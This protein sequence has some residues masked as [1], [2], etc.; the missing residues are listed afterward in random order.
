MPYGY[1]LI[2]HNKREV[3]KGSDLLKLDL[4]IADAASK[5]KASLTTSNGHEYT[6]FVEEDSKEKLQQ[7]NEY[8]SEIQLGEILDDFLGEIER[9][10]YQGDGRAK[11][12]RNKRR[13]GL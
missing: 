3:Y 1:V 8:K 4:L 10:N 7:E 2:D 5:E 9:A 12:R 11:N 6:K 13:R